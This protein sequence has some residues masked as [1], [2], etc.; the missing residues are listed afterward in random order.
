MAARLR[1]V[2]LMVRDPLATA[3]FFKEAIGVNIRHQ[4]NNMIE[5]DSGILPIIIKE[6]NNAASLS[7]GFSPMLTFDVVDMDQSI[8]A[9]LGLGAM[10]D[11]PIKYPAYGKVS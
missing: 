3:R 9:A 6:G 4:T 1:N 2:V 8:T 10:L 5:L 11:G 7:M